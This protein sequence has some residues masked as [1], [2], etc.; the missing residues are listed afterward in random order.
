MKK[1]GKVINFDDSKVYVVTSNKEFITLERNDTTPVKGSMYTGVVFVDHSNSIKLF[2]III[3]V[4]IL[5]ISCIYFIFLAPKAKII[6]SLDTNIKIG[7][8]NNKIVKITDS[9][10]SNMDMEDYAPIKGNELNDG[11]SL[12]FDTAVSEK[13]IP[14]VDEYSPGK[15]YIYITKDHKGEPLNFDVFKDYAGKFNY[16]VII[17]RNDNTLPF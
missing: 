17:N 16:E 15:I 4:S 1:S 8:N 7:I 10:G 11:L 12:L 3:A 6:V 2:F 13:L 5:I 9:S 14:V